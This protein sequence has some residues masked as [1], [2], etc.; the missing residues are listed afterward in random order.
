MIGRTISHYRIIEKLG[1]GGMGVVYKAEDTRLHR[2]VA[3]KFLPDDLAHDPQALPRFHPRHYLW[4]SKL[5]GSEKLQLADFYSWMPTW[6]PD[7]KK[8]AF[9]NGEELYLVSVDGGSAE[10][11]TSEGHTEVAPSWWPDGK[12]IAFNDYPV[13]GQ[14][15]G[16]RVLD[17][18]TGKIS[19]MPGSEG[20]YVPSWSPDG[21]CMVAIAQNPSRMV[22]YSAQSRTWKDLKKFE[23]AWG[24]WAWADDS[25][26]IYMAMKEAEP[27]GQP[28]IYRLTIADGKWNQ[29]A[30]LNG[31]TVS[32]D[33]FEGF[34]SVT[35]DGQLTMMS[36]TSVVQIYSAKW[37]K[38]SDLH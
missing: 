22:V 28:G 30:T 23:A 6:S 21:K 14:I 5:D 29:V 13:P 1:G 36:D 9:S 11:L 26:S 37:T 17:L 35:S 8:I 12:M 27:G 33:G 7:S 10:K 38:G 31:L 16:I 32:P 3:L 20:F 34:P 4:R 18:A 24:Y 25:K 15:N 2:F 19:I